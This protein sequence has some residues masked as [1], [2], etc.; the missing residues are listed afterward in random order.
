M[1]TTSYSQSFVASRTPA[2]ICSGVRCLPDGNFRGVCCPVARN[3]TLV[4]P[5]SMT[6]IF[7][8]F[9]GKCSRT[10]LGWSPACTACVPDGLFL[11][12]NR[13]LGFAKS[14]G[15][16]QIAMPYWPEVI[17]Q[18]VR[19]WHSS[20][21]VSL[22]DGFRRSGRGDVSPAP[23]DYCRE[24]RAAPDGRQQVYVRPASKND[25]R[26]SS[27]FPNA[28]GEHHAPFSRM[29]LVGWAIPDEA[30]AGAVLGS[31]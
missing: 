15:L 30:P 16:A 25:S 7:I 26:G 31:H 1:E 14:F 23:A 11:A 29:S 22:D 4:P 24:R 3:F 17:N 21:D 12:G 9:S 28:E 6:R 2:T 10:T 8:A 5:M 18:F 27:R 20:E 19:Q 13:L